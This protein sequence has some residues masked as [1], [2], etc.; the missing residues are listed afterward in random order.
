MTLSNVYKSTCSISESDKKPHERAKSLNKYNSSA[1]IGANTIPDNSIKNILP[2]TLNPYS[3]V[4]A[5][6]KST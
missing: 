1:I 6:S 5:F 3:G 2:I 4:T